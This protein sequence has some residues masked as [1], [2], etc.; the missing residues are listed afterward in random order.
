MPA[1][2]KRVKL[3]EKQ[4][5]QICLRWIRGESDLQLAAVFNVGERTVARV[6]AEAG[7]TE[8]DRAAAA[9]KQRARPDF[10][11][12]FD[13]LGPA[14]SDPI[15][16]AEWV[17][18]HLHIAMRQV[19]SDPDL[20]ADPA[21]RVNRIERLARTINASTPTALIGRAV[22]L[23]KGDAGER[24]AKKS[25]PKEQ[26][27]SQFGTPLQGESKRGQQRRVE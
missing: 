19:R 25:G 2:A 21:E 8:D 4:R 16:A 9:P 20:D 22:R 13:A 24:D 12:E 1:A 3:T 23:I 7:V 14:P 17:L 5:V 6:R 27:A 26:P 15:Q 11:E 10:R 18:R